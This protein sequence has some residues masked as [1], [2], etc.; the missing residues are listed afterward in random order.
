MSMRED[1]IEETEHDP[2]VYRLR[3]Y[4]TGTTPR[5]A[6]AIINIQRICD[7]EL[8]GRYDLE[9]VDIYQ[10]PAL[11]E[12]EQ[13]VAVPTLVKLLPL[14]LRRLVGDLS[15][16]EKVLLGLDIAKRDREE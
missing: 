1:E 12:G 8:R 2:E 14:P 11:A 9:I 16:K 4:V 10:K 13:I 7:S 3:L 6:S 15:D 5:S